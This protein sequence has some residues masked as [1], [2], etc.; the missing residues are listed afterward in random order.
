MVGTLAAL[1]FRPKLLEALQ[2]KV[3]R[4]RARPE[5]GSP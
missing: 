3:E 1:D 2:V 5:S 4:P